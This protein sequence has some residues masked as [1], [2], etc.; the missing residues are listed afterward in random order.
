MEINKEEENPLLIK[1]S[2][3]SKKT[4]Q[5]CP[6]KYFFNYIEKAPKKTWLHFDIGNLCHKTLELFHYNYIKNGTHK[7]SLSEMMGV[8]FA[9]ARKSY[10]DMSNDNLEEVKSMLSDYL[11]SVKENGMPNVK[12]TEIGFSFNIDKD[13]LMRGFI[14]R[15]DIMKDGRFHIVDYKTT[16]N[17]Q[18][19]DDFQLLVYGIWLKK[20]YPTIE[21][22]RGS[23]VLL[24]HKSALK[25]FDFNLSDVDIVQNELIEYASKIREENSWVPIP[26][27]LCNWCDF[28]D[29]C[30]AQQQ[31]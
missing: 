16:K 2:A 29:I 13:V 10:L 30:P 5:Q 3:S 4:Y 22:F 15:L 26:S 6:R 28:Y 20:E 17:T 7:M 27:R 11:A 25:S 24:K 14:D 31:W 8:S 1:L 18:Y 21:S 9:E 23:Y 19:L 12:G